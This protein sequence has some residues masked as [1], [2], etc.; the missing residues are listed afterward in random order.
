MNNYKVS[1]VVIVVQDMKDNVIYAVE[2][3]GVYVACTMALKGRDFQ[4]ISP[5]AFG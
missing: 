4:S 2:K 1:E 3:V 5:I